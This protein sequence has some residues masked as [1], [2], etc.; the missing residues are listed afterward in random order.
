MG[1][2]Q[3]NYVVKHVNFLDLHLQNITNVY[4]KL[5]FGEEG[6]NRGVVIISLLR[7]YYNLI[8]FLLKLNSL[9]G[10]LD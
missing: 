8:A 10:C 1:Q 7:P 2:F 5:I 3:Y 4:T 6:F 9:R